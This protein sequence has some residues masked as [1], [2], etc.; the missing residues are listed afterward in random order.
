MSET[1]DEPEFTGRKWPQETVSMALRAHQKVWY[2]M[3]HEY[4]Y[5]PGLAST[6]LDTEELPLLLLDPDALEWNDR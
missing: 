4:F 3:E 5:D 2:P 6:I 1:L